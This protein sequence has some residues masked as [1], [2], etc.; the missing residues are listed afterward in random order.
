MC[1]N[2]LSVMSS[3]RHNIVSSS[4]FEPQSVKKSAESL[5]ICCFDHGPIFKVKELRLLNYPIF[6]E[7][8]RQFLLN[9]YDYIIWRSL[10]ADDDFLCLTLISV[11]GTA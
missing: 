9:L 2:Y 4:Q 10:M 3:L 7:P 8:V 1:C 6:L 5:L 11:D